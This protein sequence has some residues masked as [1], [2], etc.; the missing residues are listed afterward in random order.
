L[1][2]AISGL[3]KDKGKDHTNRC[4]PTVKKHGRQKGGILIRLYNEIVAFY[5]NETQNKV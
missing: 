3:E 5:I 4:T 1:D 2:P